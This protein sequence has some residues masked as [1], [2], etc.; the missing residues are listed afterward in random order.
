MQW[1]NERKLDDNNHNVIKMH[2]GD[3]I[4]VDSNTKKN[5]SLQCIFIGVKGHGNFFTIKLPQ[6][7][8]TGVLA[9]RDN[10]DGGVV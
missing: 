4:V 3:K 6:V 2:I 7:R 10:G 8:A 1:S 9:Y 5:W